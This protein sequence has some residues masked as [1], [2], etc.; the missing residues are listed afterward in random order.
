MK[1][2]G[3][4]LKKNPDERFQNATE[5]F[6]DPWFEGFEHERFDSEE[7]RP[8]APYDF[9]L[10]TQRTPYGEKFSNILNSDATSSGVSQTAMAKIE[11]HK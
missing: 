7:N 5:M 1:F 6:N 4:L 11:E 2:V 8:A 9:E 3:K 10:R